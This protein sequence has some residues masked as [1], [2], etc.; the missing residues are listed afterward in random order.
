MLGGP[1]GGLPQSGGEADVKAS[2]QIATVVRARLFELLAANGVSVVRLFDVPGNF[3]ERGLELLD[4]NGVQVG[5]IATRE[6]FG[7]PTSQVLFDITASE[8]LNM[9]SGGDMMVSSPTLVDLQSGFAS[10]EVAAAAGG[11]I[12][13]AAPASLAIT[14]PVVKI[15]G[16][17]VAVVTVTD[18]LDQRLAAI[19]G[20]GP[21]ATDAELAAATAGSEPAGLPVAAANWSYVAHAVTRAGNVISWRI[22]MQRTTSALAV[23]STTGNVAAQ[24]IATLPAEWRSPTFAGAQAAAGAH[25]GGRGAFGDVIP[26]TGVVR[27]LAVGGTGN[28]AIGENLGLGG[29]YVV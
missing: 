14:S 27:L 24:A 6:Y 15:N 23:T 12:D 19:E 8:A 13:M 26:T 4:D 7:V 17:R 25:L 28:V 20:L 11:R 29:S 22:R 9:S 1:I 21:L 3:F 5:T 2:E 16:V 18:A 10:V